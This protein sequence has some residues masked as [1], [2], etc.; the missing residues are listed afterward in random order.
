MAQLQPSVQT[1]D[2]VERPPRLTHPR[3]VGRAA[4]KSGDAVIQSAATLPAQSSRIRPVRICLFG[5][6]GGGNYGN[7]GSLESL[8]LVL[9]R[10]RP[11][12][13]LA[14]VCVDPDFIARKHEIPAVAISASGFSSPLLKLY[15]KISMRAVGRLTNWVRAIR[16]IRRFDIVMVPGTSTL[17]DYRS[18]PFGTPYGLFRWAAAARLCGVK[19]CFVGTGAGPIS[20]NLSLWMLRYAASWAYYR[21]FRD[22]VSKDFLTGI[23]IDTSRDLVHPDL[24]FE[25]PLPRLPAGQSE[26][27]RPTTIGIGL[28]YYDGW[29][30]QAGAQVYETYLAKM[31]GFV[32]SLLDRGYRVRLLI[33]EN[34]DRRAVEDVGKITAA[35]GYHLSDPPPAVAEAGQLVTESTASLHDVMRQ[36]GDT[37][38]VIATRFHNIVCALKLARPTVSLCYEAKGEALMADFGLGRF[39]Q[40]IEHLDVERLEM[41]TTELLT[42]KELWT[43]RIQQHLGIIDLRMKD[44]EE[45]LLATIL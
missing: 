7:D 44:L 4:G 32:T 29:Q 14:C 13:E 31:A 22:Q 21:S 35:R 25:L 10:L 5:M 37:D 45:R 17:C 6:F 42:N 27:K 20:R 34:V 15:D 39:S 12:A 33:G 23:G 43:D 41:Q 36:I 19:F 26:T 30:V 9:R 18:G 3:L 11:D 24:V 2:D 40:F 38:I 1:A 16:H 28:M 8:L